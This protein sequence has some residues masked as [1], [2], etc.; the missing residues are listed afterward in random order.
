M[1][2]AP[3]THLLSAACGARGPRY[4]ETRMHEFAWPGRTSHLPC[5]ALRPGRWEP[6]LRLATSGG[7]EVAAERFADELA[8]CR[9][10]GF[11]ASQ[12]LLA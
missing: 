6:G 4:T 1:S 7:S 11:G 12:Q 10:F 8:R 9:A 2:A 5:S 3:A